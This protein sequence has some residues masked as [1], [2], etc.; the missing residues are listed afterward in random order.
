MNQV[1]DTVLHRNVPHHNFGEYD[2]RGVLRIADDR[3]RLHVRCAKKE[4]EMVLE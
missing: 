1:N 3:V 4:R 2:A